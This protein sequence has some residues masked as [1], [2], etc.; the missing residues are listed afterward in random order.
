M[1]E[2]DK[3]CPQCEE[4]YEAR[5]TDQVYCTQRCKNRHNN[6]KKRQEK[7]QATE[8]EQILASAID[9]IWTNR[10]IL[11]QFDGQE[12]SFQDLLHLGF[13]DGYLT[14]FHTKK[15]QKQTWF[16]CGDYAYQF[17][18]KTSVRIAYVN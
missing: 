1:E 15:G 11:K 3:Q 16:Y 12:V 8:K 2:Y 17:L 18:N 14:R 13:K 10:E 5:R 4:Y 9:R 6:S 7:K